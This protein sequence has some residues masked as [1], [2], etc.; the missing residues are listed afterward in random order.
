MQAANSHS[1]SGQS[2]T[3]ITMLIVLPLLG[4]ITSTLTMRILANPMRYRH[5]IVQHKQELFR[6]LGGPE[7]SLAYKSMWLRKGDVNDVNKE[8]GYKCVNCCI[9]S[10]LLFLFVAWLLLFMMTFRDVHFYRKSGGTDIDQL[11]SALTGSIDNMA[12]SLCSSIDNPETSSIVHSIDNMGMPSVSHSIQNMSIALVN[13]NNA[14]DLW[15][16][17]WEMANRSS[18]IARSIDDFN[19]SACSKPCSKS[20][21]KSS[22]RSSKSTSSASTDE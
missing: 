16:W 11:S 2:W 5:Y 17:R 9:C 14:P 15:N 6:E 8:D 21:S 19:F 22:S 20:C 4:M 3:L 7:E 10:L 1:V 18:A 12:K 13:S